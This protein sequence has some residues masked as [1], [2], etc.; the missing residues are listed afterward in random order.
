[1]LVNIDGDQ[2]NAYRVTVNGETK[3]RALLAF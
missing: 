1:M 3:N 2:S